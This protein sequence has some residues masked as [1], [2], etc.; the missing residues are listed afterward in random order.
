MAQSG[1]GLVDVG[2]SG[3]VWG[4]D[5]GY[6]LM[7]G[8]EKENIRLIEPALQA[9]AP[10]PDQGWA[11]VGVRGAGHFAKMVHNAIEYGMMQAYA[12]GFAL[13]R[14]KKAYAFDLGQVAEVW[15]HGSVIRS[16]LLDLNAGILQKD[17]QLGGAGAV[18]PD[19]GEG[20]WAAIESIEQGTPAPV[21][22]MALQARFSKS[23]TGRQLCQPPAVDDAQCLRWTCRRRRQER[24][25]MEP[26]TLV[27]FGA[28]GNLTRI[29]LMPALFSLDAD[30]R[31]PQGMTVISF[32]RREWD[33]ERWLEEVAGMLREKLPQ[34]V[35]EEALKRFLARQHYHQGDLADPAALQSLAERFSGDGA[36]AS[37][38]IFYLAIPPADFGPAVENLSAAGLLAQNGNWRRVVIE[39]PFGYDL[40]SAKMLQQSLLRH[41]A[42]EQIYR[43]DHYLGKATVQ[44]ILVFRFANL[45]L[46]PLWNRNYVDHVQITHSE[47][48]G[49][50]ER[51]GYYEGAGALRDM[52]QSHLMQLLAL[53]AMEPPAMMDAE[54]LRDEKVKVLKSI[55]P[56]T[57]SAVHAHAFRGQY[58][59]GAIGD[60]AVRGYS[61]EEGVDAGSVTETYAAL[62]LYVDNW[63]WRGVPFYLRTGKRMAQAG[64]AI[65]I[66]GAAAPSVSATPSRAHHAQLVAAWHTAA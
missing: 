61:D 10:A 44:N 26:C 37:N 1:I 2:T 12:E 47:T 55:R 33:R 5:N 56:I 16:W 59:Q 41:L 50:G 63:R 53:V 45:L 46:E 19:S 35:D 43:I 14:G 7:V 48:Q 25:L 52:L 51:A 13:L 36:L 58:A 15:R 38:I 18:V 3:G 60:V 30:G 66:A 40:L 9:L 8:G 42:E 20:R 57:Q 54:S 64:S 11:H 39:K 4:L 62:K 34:G 29:K 65:A 31:L 28:T 32:A 17:P 24:R 22:G 23:A 21:L 27:I 6:S 49:I